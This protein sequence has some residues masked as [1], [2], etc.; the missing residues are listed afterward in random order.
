MRCSTN[1]KCGC[2]NS[3]CAIPT[4]I[5][6]CFAVNCAVTSNAITF[7]AIMLL[8]YLST[9][10][11]TMKALAGEVT[12]KYALNGETQSLLIK[13]SWL[14][15]HLHDNGLVVVDTRT[16]SK[17][18]AGHIDNA[19]NLPVA[20]TFGG[21]PRDDLVAPISH[22]QAIFSN[23]GIG[24]ETHV[25]V[26]DAGN[27][28]DAARVFWVLE[29]YG[30]Q[31]V[32]LL[33]GGYSLWYKRKLPTSNAIVKHAPA[34]FIP[35]IA[36]EHLSTKFSTRLAI[37]D[38]TKTIIDARTHKEYLGLTS[39]TARHGHIPN[40]INI[41]FSENI[42]TV[43]GESRIKSIPQLKAIYKG[44][45]RDKKVIAY[46]NRG[47]QSA[48]TYFILRELGF[49]VSAYD[50]SW[51]EWSMD[52]SLPIIDPNGKLHARKTGATPVSHA[53]AE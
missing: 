39:K 32:A 29:V 51:F 25:I 42:E 23:A 4:G 20:S 38:S 14:K 5:V 52:S 3:I 34:Q 53:M 47:K 37:D 24:N 19:I 36:P 15:S 21:K 16:A 31:H 45:D 48:L 44:I 40:A 6:R 8:V 9:A 41:P 49:N 13:P 33:D 46:C 1:N 43:A 17:Y 7:K 50:G 26:Y 10:L 11:Y 18:R 28:I 2:I 12:T 27:F 35:T 30:H 22:I